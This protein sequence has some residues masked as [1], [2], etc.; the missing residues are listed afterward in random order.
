MIDANMTEVEVDVLL[1]N[2]IMLQPFTMDVRIL[3]TWIHRSRAFYCE[4]AVMKIRTLQWMRT[5]VVCLLLK[6]V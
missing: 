2:L 3:L 5:G 6:S 4:T 1:T